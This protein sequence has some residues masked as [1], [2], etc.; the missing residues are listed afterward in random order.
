MYLTCYVGLF[1]VQVPKGIISIKYRLN[2]LFDFKKS[3][4]KELV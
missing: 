2:F 3:I 1:D 4:A